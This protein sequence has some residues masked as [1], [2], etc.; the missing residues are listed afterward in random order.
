M[1]KGETKIQSNHQM[2]ISRTMISLKYHILSKNAVWTHFEFFKFLF[3]FPLF[4]LLLSQSKFSGTKKNLLGD[5]NSLR[6]TLTLRCRELT[7][8]RSKNIALFYPL[9]SES[10]SA[11]SQAFNDM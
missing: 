1:T 7:V 4:K 11:L 2:S 8:I 6:G 3:H 9:P 10:C 5:I